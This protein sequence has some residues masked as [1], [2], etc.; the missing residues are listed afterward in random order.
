MWGV[1]SKEVTGFTRATTT[2]DFAGIRPYCNGVPFF[3]APLLNIMEAATRHPTST[4]NKTLPTVIPDY[5]ALYNAAT[6]K[7]TLVHLFKAWASQPENK[8][9]HTDEEIALFLDQLT[10]LVAAAEQLH[11]TNRALIKTNPS[12]TKENQP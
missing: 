6:T 4:N 1:T 8:K 12:P 9:Q 3:T 5:F 2:F 10:S 7:N 11:Q